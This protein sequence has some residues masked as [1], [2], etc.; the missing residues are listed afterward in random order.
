MRRFKVRY[1]Y[2]KR[3]QV[4]CITWHY[5]FF[6]FFLPHYM[7]V[8]IYVANN[9]LHTCNNKKTKQA[10]FLW[11]EKKRMKM[12]AKQ[13]KLYNNIESWSWSVYISNNNARH[14][15][16]HLRKYL[17]AYWPFTYFSEVHLSFLTEVLCVLHCYFWFFLSCLFYYFEHIKL[18]FFFVFCYFLK[19]C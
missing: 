11:F 12:Y 8:N 4:Q 10:T 7:A 14:N 16:L 6:L 3:V 17:I 5:Y 15:K 9:L 18:L 13:I 19:W 1:R 2:V